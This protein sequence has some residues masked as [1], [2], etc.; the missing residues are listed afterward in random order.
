MTVAKHTHTYTQSVCAMAG[1]L[2]AADTKWIRE[3]RARGEGGLGAGGIK[4]GERGDR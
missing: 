4:V 3:E 1:C 2:T